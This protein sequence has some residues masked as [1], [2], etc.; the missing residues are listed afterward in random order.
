ML[1]DRAGVEEPGD[2]ADDG[3]ELVV[4]EA[5]DEDAASVMAVGFGPLPQ[6]WR[7]VPG[8]SGHQDAGLLG[9]ELE[10]LRVIQRA[11]SCISRKADHVVAASG[12]PGADALG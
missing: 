8:V 1:G 5:P 12:E 4:T 10:H 7:E 11:E 9:G 3:A 2:A 6:Q